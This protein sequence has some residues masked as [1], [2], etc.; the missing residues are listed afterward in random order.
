MAYLVYLLVQ[1]IVG[2]YPAL[3]RQFYFYR[4]KDYFIILEEVEE[5]IN[6][7]RHPRVKRALEWIRNVNRMSLLRLEVRCHTY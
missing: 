5:K 3:V 2:Y 7:D 1:T 4:D 6:R